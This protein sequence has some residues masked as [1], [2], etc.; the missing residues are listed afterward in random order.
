MPEAAIPLVA[1]EAVGTT[2][3]ELTAEQLAAQQAAAAAQAAQAAEAAQAAQAAQEATRQAV[4]DTVTKTPVS[5]AGTGV[6]SLASGAAPTAGGLA[7]STLWVTL[8]FAWFFPSMLRSVF[9]ASS[10]SL[11]NNLFSLYM[12][13]ASLV[14]G[15]SMPCLS[16]Y[17]RAEF[18]LDIQQR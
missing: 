5:T 6:S 12:I 10:T 1:E 14:V 16:R 13:R 15:I 4:L 18:L 8:A 11:N 17:S 2:A 7:L 9:L 3:A